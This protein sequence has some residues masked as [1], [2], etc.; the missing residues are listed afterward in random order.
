MAGIIPEVAG[1]H[2]YRRSPAC[3]QC[4][5]CLLCREKTRGCILS[6]AVMEERMVTPEE[7]VCG[8]GVTASYGLENYKSQQTARLALCVLIAV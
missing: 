8:R 6:A 5:L 2:L 4:D 3:N 1:C 7:D